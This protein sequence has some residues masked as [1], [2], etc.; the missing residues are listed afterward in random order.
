M[1]D[2]KGNASGTGAGGVGGAEEFISAAELLRMVL[3]HRRA[4]ALF[5]IVATA[6]TA[7]YSLFSPRQY[8][9]EGFLQVIP[10]ITAIDEK[11]DR[12][13]F[14]TTINSHLHAI[15]S[16]FIAKEV[17]GSI[18]AGSG[19]KMTS[20]EL[21]GRV[22]ITRPP[23]SS[24]IA[25]TSTAPSPE[26][27]IAIVHLW[28]QKYR[29]TIC[30][31]N[32]SAAL[33]QVRSLL[34]KAQA[35]LMESEAKVEYIK[36]R[37]GETK[38]VVSLARGIENNELWR[39]ISSEATAEKIKNLSK[40]QISDQEQSEDYVNLKTMLYVANQE[41][42]GTIG[43]RDFLKDVETYLEYKSLD[44]VNRAEAP[45]NLSSNA[46]QFA[47]TL[48]KSTDVIAMGEPA[49]KSSGR[50]ALRKTAIA[51]FASLFLASLASCLAEWYKN[52]V[53]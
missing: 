45:A 41:L 34:K 24:L 31:N 14:E 50:G 36:S 17:A 4:I 8:K 28:I 25:L 12:D 47:E 29:S 2:A 19:G 23:K 44:T 10:P 48:L 7:A 53:A 22:K 5:T 46:V 42:A 37:A 52:A 21:Q 32:I 13:L 40:I 20:E 1:T 3:K 39:E 49:L 43:K 35:V 38:P 27:A 16:A 30:K 6:I 26:L 33:S 51:F 11:V 15:Q 18:N 9:A